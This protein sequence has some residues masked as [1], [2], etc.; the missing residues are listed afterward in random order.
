MPKSPI[1]L[2]LH[3]LD[4]LNFLIEKSDKISEE[5]FQRNDLYQ[6]AFVRSLEVIG[7]ASK[8]IP[9]EFKTR[10]SSLPWKEMARMRDRL[11]HHYFGID[12]QLVWDTVSNDIPNLYQ[13]I[14]EILENEM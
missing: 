2:L 3:M 11:I 9:Q 5:E 8:S 1:D 12:Y 4:E 14:N 7:E 10:H 13:Q 6:R